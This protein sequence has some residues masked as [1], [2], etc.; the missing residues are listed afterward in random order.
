MCLV[1]RSERCS[2]AIGSGPHTTDNLDKSIKLVVVEAA[3]D[4]LLEEGN[5]VSS[6]VRVPQERLWRCQAPHFIVGVR[7][8]RAGRRWLVE[9][10]TRKPS[11]CS[12]NDTDK[13]DAR[14]SCKHV[15][16]VEK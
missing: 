9:S 3:I 11:V 7:I 1:T 13:T 6:K 16:C 14:K 4:C 5:C 8:T 15:S 2:F 10:R 12:T